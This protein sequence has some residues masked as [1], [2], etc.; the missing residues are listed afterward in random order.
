MNNIIDI[1][2]TAAVQN[3][4]EINDKNSPEDT[5]YNSVINSIDYNENDFIIEVEGRAELVKERLK[6]ILKVYGESFV[7]L[8]KHLDISYQALSKKVNGHV[9]FKLDEV[10]KIKQFYNLD[11]KAI[12]YVFIDD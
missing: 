4:S 2:E 7:D 6:E 8:A 5:E 12:C 11:N 1:E 3:G 9:D 10:R